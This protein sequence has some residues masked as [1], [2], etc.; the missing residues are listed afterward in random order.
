VV[1][2]LTAINPTLR[3]TLQNPAA[4]VAHANCTRTA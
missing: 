1:V 3:V 4:P 2:R